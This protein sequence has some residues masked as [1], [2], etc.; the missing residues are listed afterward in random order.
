MSRSLYIPPKNVLQKTNPID[1]VYW[2]YKPLLGYVY[3]KRLSLVLDALG[4]NFDKLI[5]VGYASGILLP[6]LSR[7]CKELHAVDIH[8]QI[9]P[10]QDMLASENIHAHLKV[11]SV[12]DLKYASNT[13]DALVCV[14]V[15]E[16]IEKK[17]LS[18]ALKEI[19]RITKT[20]G[21]IILGFP[22]YNRVIT[23]FYRMCGYKQ[24][25]LY[26]CSDLDIL[27]NIKAEFSDF[28]ISYWPKTNFQAVYYVC[29]CKS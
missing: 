16:F 5:E 14:S 29:R 25:D 2:Y 13:F 12:L 11:G 3:R 18:I 4:S 26:V 20:G 24:T 15:L 8:N 19:H 9:I 17:N 7:H 6:E 21:E 1:P 22:R 27:D 10:V 23:L 28:S